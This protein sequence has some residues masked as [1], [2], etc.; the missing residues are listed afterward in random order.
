MKLKRNIIATALMCGIVSGTAL[1]QTA[2]TVLPNIF[3][4][5]Y[6]FGDSYSDMGSFG[7]NVGWFHN[8]A[9]AGTTW[10]ALVAAHYGWTASSAYTSLSGLTQAPNA[11][12]TNFAVGGARVADGTQKGTSTQINDLITRAGGKLD[13]K[14]LYTIFIGG[15]DVSPN[16][17]VGLTTGSTAATNNMIAAAQ[18][19]AAQVAT[20]RAAGAQNIVV[21]DLGSL[22]TVPQLTQTAAGTKAQY[23]AGAAQATA[24]AAQATAGAAAATAAAAAATTAGNTA[25]A[26]TLT[27]QAA[28]LTATA[29]SLR[30]QAATATATGIQARDGI[31]QLAS[32]LPAAYTATLRAAIPKGNAIILDFAQFGTFLQTNAAALGFTNLT[33]AVCNPSIAASTNWFTCH[34]TAGAGALYADPQHISANAH[35][36]L[37]SWVTGSLDAMYS[38]AG[39]S[40]M[41]GQVPLG[42]SGAEWRTVDSRTRAYQN[43]AY[44]GDRMFFAGDYA[45][46]RADDANGNMAADGNTKT[47]TIGYEATMGDN[48]LVGATL[49]R[50]KASFDL[51][52]NG[53]KLTYYETM[54]TAYFTKSLG[55]NLYVNGLASAGVLSF[56]SVRNATIGPITATELAHFGGRHYGVKSQAGYLTRSADFVHG[57]FVGVDWESARIDPFNEGSSSTAISVGAQSVQQAHYRVGYE[58]AGGASSA[59]RPYAQLSYDY[60]FLKNERSFFA[61]SATSG[62]SIAIS[63]RNDTGGF[64]RAAVGAS[65]S[66]GKGSELSL[67]VSS[68]FSNPAG[69]DTAVNV[70]WATAL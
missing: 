65:T 37:A 15:N 59:F 11:T 46:S 24:G 41:A 9:T 27:A 69:R 3:S 43:V 29:A 38:G 56:D 68:T 64:G 34:G 48:M 57:P 2:T 66:V 33:T 8:G 51:V 7:P 70:V 50:E 35:A 32:V 20:L 4:K 1:A 45:D 40:S 42:R 52:N 6:S 17:N 58:L 14:A 19:V 13:S 5:V 55:P 18:G 63:K 53:G 49:G 67:G 47:F 21:L 26:A 61:G 31:I 22:A 60:Q 44:K 62:S 10:T 30:T 25:G 23:D 54:V 39:I 12:G 28:T 16:I 36:V